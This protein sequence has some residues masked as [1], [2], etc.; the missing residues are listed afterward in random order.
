MDSNPKPWDDEARVLP[1]CC[2]RWLVGSTVVEHSTANPE[3]EG[4]N[5]PASLVQKEEEIKFNLLQV[6]NVKKGLCEICP[7][8][9]GL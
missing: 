1:L 6:G 8:R 9:V 4:S 7:R 2:T 5:L 3:I